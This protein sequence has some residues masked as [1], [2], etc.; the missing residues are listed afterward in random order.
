MMMMMMMMI[1]QR[2]LCN[3]GSSLYWRRILVQVTGLCSN[4]ECR[5]DFMES[6]I[7]A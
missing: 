2:N 7:N 1:I 5:M 3:T 6:E 4:N